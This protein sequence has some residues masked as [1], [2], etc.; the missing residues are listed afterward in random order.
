MRLRVCLPDICVSSSSNEVAPSSVG[1]ERHGGER[2][3]EHA[4]EVHVVEADHRELVRDPDA[5]VASGEVHA[6]GDHVV[7][8]EHRGGLLVEQRSA[9]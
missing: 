9:R 8:A 5:A 7:V 6:G 2:R 1:V 3:V 4:R